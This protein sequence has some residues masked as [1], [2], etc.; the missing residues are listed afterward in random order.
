VDVIGMGTTPGEVQVARVDYHVNIPNQ[1][2]HTTLV[3]M[4]VC[5][6]GPSDG[7]SVTGNE[8]G[9]GTHAT[10][11]VVTCGGVFLHGDGDFYLMVINSSIAPGPGDG[12]L[13][14]AFDF[15]GGT[16]DIVD[17]R[18]AAWNASLRAGVG[19]GVALRIGGDSEVR[20]SGSEIRGGSGV[21]GGAASFRNGAD[22]IDRGFG[23]GAIELRLAGETLVSGGA[24]AGSGTGG[25]GVDLAGT[26]MLGDASVSGGAGSPSGPDYATGSP[27]QLDFDPHLAVEPAQF[28]A[29]GRTVLRAGDWA[30]L[31][32]DASIPSPSIGFA[33]DIESP[34]S[35]DR[36][37]LPPGATSFVQL[38]E[39]GVR[40][41]ARIPGLSASARGH[42]YFQAFWISGG[43]TIT[44]NPVALQFE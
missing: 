22:A 35:A 37:P 7:I 13:G 44:S 15:G 21:A 29:Q 3:N 9:S 32:A 14:A 38:A 41:P 6:D 17:S 1:G 36:S 10:I 4:T 20:V 5:G 43:Q 18:I 42:G 2:Y 34:Q 33:T 23:A 24:A 26:I 31:R 19:A 27:V 39:V 12:F 11:G 40:V 8:L 16:A 25:A 28:F 30:L